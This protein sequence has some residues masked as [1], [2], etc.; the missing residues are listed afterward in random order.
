MPRAW[1]CQ[2]WGRVGVT[3]RL[4]EAASVLLV[5]A[6]CAAPALVQADAEAEAEPPAENDVTIVRPEADDDEAEA[7][8]DEAEAEE[9]AEEDEEELISIALSDVD[10]K[11]V[12]QFLAEELDQAVIVDNAILEKKVT[13]V[14]PQQMSLEAALRVLRAALVQNEVL[15]ERNENFV[16]L[17]SLEHARRG[18]LPVLDADVDLAELDQAMVVSKSYRLRHHE[19]ASMKEAVEPVISDFG[20]ITADAASRRFVVTDTVSNLRRVERIIENLDVPGHD[21]PVT[22]IIR[23]Q[24]NDAAWLVRLLQTMLGGEREQAPATGGRARQLWQQQQQRQAQAG[25]VSIE[26]NDG[27]VVLMPELTRNWIIVVAPAPVLERIEGWVSE[28]DTEEERPTDYVMVRIA[29]ADV[30]QLA[31]QLQ[32]AI[33]ALPNRDLAESVR[34]APFA[35]AR[36]IMVFGSRRGREMVRGLI[37]ELDQADVGHRVM[38]MFELRHADAA[39]IADNIEM[40]FTPQRPAGISQWAW[41][42]IASQDHGIRVTANTRRN[43]VTVFSDGETIERIKELMPEWDRPLSTDDVEPRIYQLRHADPRELRDT[44][45]G[46]FSEQ[47]SAPTSFFQLF[48]GGQQDAPPVGRLAGQFGFEALP[49]ARQLIVTTPHPENFYVIDRLI[50]RLDQPQEAGLPRMIELSHAYAEEVAEQLNTMLAESGTLAELDRTRRRLSA[51]ARG[52]SVIDVTRDAPAP[53]ADGEDDGDPG[54]MPF[55]WQQS[56]RQPEDEASTSNLIGK[57]RVVPIAR[58]N[59]LLI[60]APPAYAEPVRRLIDD[61]DKPGRQVVIHAIVAEI[62]HDD[63]TTLGVRLAS[64]PRIFDDPRLQDQAIR[65]TGA[66]NWSDIFGGTY[67]VDGQEAARGVFD[68]AFNVH[69]LVQ[70]LMREMSMHILLE[71]RLYTADNKEAEFFDGQDISVQTSAQFTPEGTQNF[72]FAYAFVG[73][74]LRVRPH[75]TH[76][77]D[78]DLHVNLELSR[79][80]P[81]ETFMGNPTIDRRETNTQLVVSNGETVMLS[82][83]I[84]QEEFRAVRKLPLLGDIPLLG[85]LFRNTDTGYR[86]REII[87]FLTPQVVA[88]GTE[89]ARELSEEHYQELERLRDEL[90]E[91]FRRPGGDAEEEDAELDAQP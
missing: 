49:G 63:A 15:L 88:A 48:Y 55:W 47:T 54:R 85:M 3:G 86:N 22:R 1:I 9:D 57:I 19:P 62:Q 35:G 91:H 66:A 12:A 4:R 8:E 72:G 82:G 46:I 76:N 36:Q 37:D 23:L 74:R 83:I 61:L 71:P 7:S 70:F 5:L 89:E 65:G 11:R 56:S 53:Q 75:I 79:V 27:D 13:I 38:H 68:A 14:A 51:R 69:A 18:D 60:L 32:Q 21:R 42:Q 34:I 17:R 31:Q 50:E 6:L 80:V 39:E 58:Q 59:A 67:T 90:P 16:L 43:T 73:T 78:V 26:T 10:M 28:L 24:H 2:R 40:L 81:G 52:E 87:V 30:T 45:D 44:L 84:E 25:S 20:H 33:D 41:A 77:G 29:H 64:D